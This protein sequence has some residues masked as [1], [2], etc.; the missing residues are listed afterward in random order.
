MST[1]SLLE[2]VWSEPFANMSPF[3]VENADLLEKKAVDNSLSRAT[4]N[5]NSDPTDNLT[6]ITAYK[7]QIAILTNQIGQLK[8]SLSESTPV[9]QLSNNNDLLIFIISGA[10][11]VCV[12]DSFFNFGRR[13][14]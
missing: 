1:Y 8:Q 12:L 4:L 3:N 6:E 13:L 11:F 14:S 7:N 5:T 10:F 9:K 2:E